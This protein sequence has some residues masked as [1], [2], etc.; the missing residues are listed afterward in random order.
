MN[1]FAKITARTM[2]RSKMRSIVTIIGVILASAMITGV[3]T[4]GY[5]VQKFMIEYAKEV[6]GDWHFYEGNLS[7]KDAEKLEK[8]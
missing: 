5:S 8:N 2:K 1:V 3:M 6:D 7:K 4:L